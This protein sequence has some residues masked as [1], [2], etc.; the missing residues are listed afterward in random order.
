ME[1]SIF[2]VN[3]EPYCIWEI[4][5]HER[6]MEFL[7]GID[8]EYFDYLVELHLNAND[9]K[10]ASIALRSTLHHAMETMFSLLGAYV[11]APDC[12]YAWIAK[13]SNSQLRDFIGNIGNHQNELFA[14]LNI[15]NVSWQEISK[16]VFCGFHPK[17]KKNEKTVKQFATLWNR[18]AH[19][20]LDQ[21]HIGE[22]NSIKH[23][24]RIRSGGFSLAMGEESAN[25]VPPPAEEMKTLGSSE[26]GTT[27]FIVE[28]IAKSKG[29][30]NLR[31]RRHSLNWRIEKTV[32]LIQLAAMSIFNVISALKIANGAESG[33]CKFLRPLEDEIFDKPWSYSTGVTSM[34]MNHAIPEDEV[35]FYS[36]SELI[37]LINEAMR[38]KR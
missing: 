13:C 15:E 24:F 4:N 5:T 38:G 36:K 29:N 12:A 1:S 23:G 34:T 31:S 9:E 27:Y 20:F 22:Y 37:N 25:G 14:K 33:T 21:S 8:T 3:D 26:Y 28:P 30:R 6:N 18:L 16:S 19:E 2:M 17:T 10:R 35:E 11:Q 7:N 32:L